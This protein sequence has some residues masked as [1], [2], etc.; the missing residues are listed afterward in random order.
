MGINNKR[1]KISICIITFNHERYIADCLYSVIFQES[2]FDIEILVG[3]D[4]STD[5][6]AKLVQD[7]SDKHPGAIKFFRHDVNI[8]G[9]KNYQ[10]LHERSSGDYVAHLDGD[11]FW[12]PGKLQAQFDFLQ[13]HPECAAVYSNAI[14]ITPEKELVGVFNRRQPEVFDCSYLLKEEN[15]LNASSLFY[16]AVFKK[17]ITGIEGDFLDYRVHLRLSQYGHMGYLNQ[18]L[19]GYRLGVA[20]SALANIPDKVKELYWDAI[21]EMRSTQVDANALRNAIINFFALILYGFLR[22]GR[23]MDAYRWWRRISREADLQ[24]KRAL[25]PSFIRAFF[26]GL[27]GIVDKVRNRVGGSKL[28]ILCKR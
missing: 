2:N 18:T 7:I 14:V 11:D 8:G 5:N 25:Y 26:L 20:T 10:Y 21:L 16:R 9:C 15:F 17:A 24:S 19:V 4:C 12:L 1:C 13:A 6:T 22:Q 27:F 3:D 28:R 23:I